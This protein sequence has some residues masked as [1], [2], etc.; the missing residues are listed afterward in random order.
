MTDNVVALDSLDNFRANRRQRNQP[1]QPPTDDTRAIIRLEASDLHNVVERFDQL[2]S[3]TSTGLYRYGSELVHVVPVDIRVAGGGSELSMHTVQVKPEH[4]YGVCSRVAR[5]EKWHAAS[6]DY[7]ACNPPDKLPLMYLARGGWSV[8]PLL[9]VTTAPTMRADGSILDVPG[10]DPTSAL[11]YAPQGARFNAIAQRPTKAE[12]ELAIK[13]LI[14]PLR[15][16]R[17][18][19]DADLSVALSGVLTA[20]TRHAYATAPLHA[21]DA[22]VAGSGK[23]KLVDYASVIATGHGAF[24]TSA[25][26]ERD[27]SKELDKKL[28]ASAIAGEPIV[29][30]DN[31]ETALQSAFLCQL[32]TQT[33][34]QI[35]VFHT[36]KNLSV[37]STSTYFATGNNLIISGDLIRRTMVC[38]VEPEVE[39]PELKTY[40]FDP[41]E[42]ARRARHVLLPAALTVVRAYL[43]SG[44]IRSVRNDVF[45]LGSYPGWTRFV[46]EPLVWLGY[47]D[48]AS[49]IERNRDTDPRLNKLR[50]LFTAWARVIGTDQEA[51]TRDIVAKALKTTLNEDLTEEYANQ[52]LLDALQACAGTGN[53]RDRISNDK[54]GWFLRQNRGKIVRIEIDGYPTNVRFMEAARTTQGTR[55]ILQ[56]LDDQINREPGEEG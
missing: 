4:L 22:A 9:G 12:A 2:L 42:L 20:V 31:L 16:Y 50:S 21:F 53:G 54:L 14:K 3:Q 52:D 38:R 1:P 24:V 56:R 51:R 10:Y 33:V 7:V 17:F 35:R 32:L 13:Q 6:E 37:P 15:Q 34:V 44:E 36:Q 11:I 48:P 25:D 5:F 55:W 26:D 8:P 30:L 28:S 47:A 40:L 45:S 27:T 46:R 43:T 19:T 41:V 49:V 29:A 23:S 39:R 18:Y